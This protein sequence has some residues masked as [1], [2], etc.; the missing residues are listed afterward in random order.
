MQFL[1]LVILLYNGMNNSHANCTDE[2]CMKCLIVLA[3]DYVGKCY[4]A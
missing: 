1:K 2:K 3:V 4:A